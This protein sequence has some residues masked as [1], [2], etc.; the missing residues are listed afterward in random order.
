VLESTAGRLPC[1]ITYH[2]STGLPF[3]ALELAAE[4]HCQLQQHAPHHQPGS[5]PGW[6]PG[7]KEARCC[8]QGFYP[9]YAGQAAMHLVWQP[10]RVS[11]LLADAACCS[12]LRSGRCAS[13]Y[14]GQ[15]AMRQVRQPYRMLGSLV[16]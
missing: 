10:Y 15:A 11:W 3:V 7:S 9:C 4:Q 13:C 16:A 12:W 1:R 8:W 2:K 5:N 14:A 6:L